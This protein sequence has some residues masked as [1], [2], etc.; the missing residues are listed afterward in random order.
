MFGSSGSVVSDMEV[1][2]DR[3]AHRRLDTNLSVDAVSVWRGGR[4]ASG[5]ADRTMAGK[6]VIYPSLHEVGLLSL[7]DLGGAFPTVASKLADG[8][9]CLEAE[10]E[11]LKVAG[12]PPPAPADDKHD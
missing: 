4:W 1:L 6:I 7:A 8:H 9:W 2:L 11:L 10:R 5:A 3:I 12:S